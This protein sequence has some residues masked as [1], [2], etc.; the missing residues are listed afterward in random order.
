M[1]EGTVTLA[2]LDDNGVIA[3]TGA[4]PTNYRTLQVKGHGAHRITRPEMDQLVVRHRAAFVDEVCAVGLARAAA[5]AM[6]STRF[7]A[8]AF[9]PDA[10]FGQAPGPAAG[11]VLGA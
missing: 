8:I 1:P 3:L 2:N 9:V 5:N 6:W 11:L 7:V 10:L 4:R